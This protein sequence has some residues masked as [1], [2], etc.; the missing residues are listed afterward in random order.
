MAK[1]KGGKQW[2]GAGMLLLTAIIWGSAFVAQSVGMESIGPFTFS[3][4]RNLFGVVTLLPVILLRDAAKLRGA[5]AEAR[6]AHR[7]DN[8]RVLKYGAILGVIYFVAQNLQQHAFYYS[9]AGKI[10]FITSLYMIFVPLLGIFLGK[11]VGLLTWFCVLL[12][13]VGLFLLSINPEDMTALNQGDLLTLLCAVFYAMQ[14]LFIERHAPQVDPIKLA[15]TQFF[16]G[17]ALSSVPMLLLEQPYLSD[18]S[19]ALL[20]LLYAGVLSCGFAYTF[21][22]IGQQY[23]EATVASLLMCTESVFGVFFG[24]LLLQESLSTREL[25]GCGIMLVAIVLSQVA[26]Y[27]GARHAVYATASAPASAPTP[28]PAPAP[29]DSMIPEDEEDFGFSFISLDED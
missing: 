9:T 6:R 10:A 8:R 16:V 2:F 1:T 26:E 21:Q 20:P 18:I 3:A 28:V 25:I 11:R 24:W 13:F 7:A 12:G 15:A 23:T 14:I 17:G 27:R 5:D 4:V 22:I 29:A 19:A